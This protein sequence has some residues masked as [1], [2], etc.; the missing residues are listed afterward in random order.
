MNTINK[1][2]DLQHE[3]SK[4]LTTHRELD[5]S[6]AKLEAAPGSNDIEL[7]RLKK[8]KLSLKDRITT[9]EK[10]ITKAK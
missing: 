2:E 5:Q 7:H 6:I 9:L 3:H 8:Q 10:L 4:L 1:T